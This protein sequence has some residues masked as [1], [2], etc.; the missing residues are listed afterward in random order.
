[1]TRAPPSLD[2]CV[3]VR[4]K[5]RDRVRE[6]DRK[7]FRKED[8][9]NIIQDEFCRFLSTCKYTCMHCCSGCGISM[10]CYSLQ[11]L[12]TEVHWSL[13]EDHVIHLRL[14]FKLSNWNLATTM[15][16]TPTNGRLCRPIMKNSRSS[17]ITGQRG[18]IVLHNAVFIVLV[19][20][21]NLFPL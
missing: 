8:I 3:C 2:L 9:Q 4:E 17:H 7:N 18:V 19:S 10:L 21:I 1:M 15:Q 16:N 12:F 6:K 14:L 11:G 20:H 5:E 13:A